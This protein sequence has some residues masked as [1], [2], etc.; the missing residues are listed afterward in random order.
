MPR[1]TKKA[2][3]S[4]VKDYF[5]L[6]YIEETNNE[7]WTNLL[8]LKEIA[9]RYMAYE[10]DDK[11]DVSL[12]KNGKLVGYIQTDPMYVKKYREWQKYY[13]VNQIKKDF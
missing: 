9:N 4:Y 5:E 6:Y 13:A 10:Y 12:S 8:I 1:I 11:D 2:V 3:H 7:Q